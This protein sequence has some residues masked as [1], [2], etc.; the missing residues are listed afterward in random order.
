[1]GKAVP[2]GLESI[3]HPPTLPVVGNVLAID[4]EDPMAS[5]VGLM[6]QY[7]PIITLKFPKQTIIA[8][9]C[10]EYVKEL[11]DQERFIKNVSG[12]LEEVRAIAKDGKL[13][14][15]HHCIA[16]ANY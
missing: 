16:S 9:G 2:S 11:C 12:A 7:G 1:M 8:V 15:G 10:Q 13:D 5:I 3:P 14:L 4:P 6:K